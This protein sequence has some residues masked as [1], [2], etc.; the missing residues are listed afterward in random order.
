MHRAPV[1]ATVRVT[2]HEDGSQRKH[3]DVWIGV[4]GTTIRLTPMRPTSPTTGDTNNSERLITEVE[5]LWLTRAERAVIEQH[6]I[7][8][9]TG[10]GAAI[11]ALLLSMPQEAGAPEGLLR[12]QILV[13]VRNLISAVGS[14][15]VEAGTVRVTPHQHLV[16]RAMQLVNAGLDDP[17]LTSATIAD[18]LGVS[19]RTL[20]AAFRDSGAAPT[21]YIW[22][23]RLERAHL[24]VALAE[25]LSRSDVVAL[26]TQ[27]GFHS[28]T[29]FSRAYERR[30]GVRLRRSG[31]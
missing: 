22:A 1:P 28:S 29:H 7:D 31:E 27:W 12:R 24:E 20:Q 9:S 23:L 11:A 13:T 17:L 19:R 15:R 14:E 18:R 6:P 2:G 30:Y 5:L 8:G 25:R 3:P 4:I 10:L 21:A 26:G 16:V